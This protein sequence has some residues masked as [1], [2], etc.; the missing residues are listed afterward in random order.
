MKNFFLLI[1]C[2]F[3]VGCASVAQMETP[4]VSVLEEKSLTNI[5]RVHIGMTSEEVANLMGDQLKIGYKETEPN[6]GMIEDITIT[7][8]YKTENL[9][10][11]NKDYQIVYY[12]TMVKHADNMIT[13]DELTPVIFKDGQ[14]VGK[15]ENFLLKL[16]RQTF[17]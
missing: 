7:N 1:I 14:V 2:F 9:K 15:G 4:S 3:I 17:K 12:Y 6:S 5:D 16:R 10:V 13:N 11:K 8:P